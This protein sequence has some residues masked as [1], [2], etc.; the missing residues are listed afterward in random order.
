MKILKFKIILPAVALLV[1]ALFAFKLLNNDKNKLILQ[2]LVKGL[3]AMHYN[4]EQIDNDFSEK[5]FKLYIDRL[6]YNKRFFTQDDINL[7]TAYKYKIDDEIKNLDFIFFDITKDLYLKRIKDASN[8]YTAA[9]KKPFDFTLDEYLETDPE[10]VQFAA[11]EKELKERWHKYMK[12]QVLTKYAQ[13]IELQEKAKKDNDTSYVA[14]TLKELEE[15]A[16]NDVKKTYDDWYY[17]ISKMNDK[18]IVSLYFNSITAFFDPHTQYFPPEDKENFDIRMSGQLEGIG[19]QLTQPNAYI[20]VAK[21]IP[22]SPCWK[23]GEL[24]AGDLI[25]KVAQADQEPVDVVDMRLDEAIKMIRGKKGT[26]VRLTIQKPDG[27]LKIIPII[28]DVI[29][30]EETFAKSIIMKDSTSDSRLAYIYLPE[31]YADFNKQNGRHCSKDI[32]KELDKI[33]K[34]KID[35]IIIDLRNNG[36]GSLMDA[37][38]IVGYFIDKG[39]VVQVRDRKQTPKVYSD[40]IAGIVYNGP[41]IIMTNEFS[42]SASEIMAAAIQDYGRGI[43]VGTNT[44][45]KGT[46]QRFFP[47]D[48]MIRGNDEHKPLGDLKITI[49]KFYRINGGS[50]QLRGV[51]PDILLPDPYQ[52]LDMGEKDTEFPIGWDEVNKAEYKNLK[53]NFSVEKIKKLSEKRTGSD[54]NFEIVENYAEYL[55]SRKDSSL[56]TLNYGKYLTNDKNSKAESK[57]FS[58]IQDQKYSLKFFVLK[59]DSVTV[60]SDTIK[61]ARVKSWIKEL[62]TDMQLNETYKIMQDMR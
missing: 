19:A 1:I 29:V 47:F 12:Y 38:E 53:Q 14:K 25:L 42:A 51:S 52:F 58:D 15:E 43:I 55:K 54:K 2:I 5:V 59:E 17:R 36:G 23:Q 60:Y 48:M 11:N 6:D 34:E 41:L 44:Y 31:F 35:G 62:E 57:K 3:Q 13:K 27:T 37:I 30:L 22:G 18:D 28:R 40:Q 26:E 32:K 7:F 24:K 10:K 4:E 20:K 45:G 61:T 9:L 16:R 21:I 50:T 33:N 56:L 49:Q 39:P 8:Y 46:V